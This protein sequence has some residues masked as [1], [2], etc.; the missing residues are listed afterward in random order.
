MKL[1]KSIS[2]I[3]VVVLVLSGLSAPTSHALVGL[4]VVGGATHT[5]PMVKTASGQGLATHPRLDFLGGALVDFGLTGTISVEGG[6][7]YVRN[8]YSSS[9]SGLLYT[10]TIPNLQVPIFF[11]YHPIRFVSLGV[12]GYYSK[13]T[14]TVK[15]ETSIAGADIDTSN[16]KDD[17]G[18]GGSVRLHIPMGV[19][20]TFIVDARYLQGFKDHESG[21]A[22]Y[23]NRQL[24]A[25]AGLRFGI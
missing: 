1:T 20:S 13:K 17:Y 3:L 7:L 9:A 14:G 15:V 12:G 18:F 11:R 21:P 22:E 10:L 25:F 4:S 16:I 24:Q 2:R 8:K 5:T 6:L 19:L 23:K